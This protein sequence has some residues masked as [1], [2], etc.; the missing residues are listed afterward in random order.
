MRI[1]RERFLGLVSVLA[2][3]AC[4]Q[5]QTSSDP[6]APAPTA[7]MTVASVTPAAVE[8]APPPATPAPPPL[9]PATPKASPDPYKGTPITAQACNPSENMV[10]GSPYACNL[11]APGP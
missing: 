6:A 10:A 9:P 4:A 3:G 1:D 8:M 11:H 2:A 7:V 5:T